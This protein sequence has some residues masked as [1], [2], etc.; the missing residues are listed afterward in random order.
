MNEQ[1]GSLDKLCQWLDEWDYKNPANYQGVKRSKFK[2]QSRNAWAARELME[3]VRRHSGEDTLE[4][5]ERFRDRMDRFCCI[6]KTE[7]AKDIFI[8]LYE[9]STN[10]L[11]YLLLSVL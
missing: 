3:E 1:N 6:A 7:D 4:V 8:S 9:V 11:D 5:V 10:A 2:Q